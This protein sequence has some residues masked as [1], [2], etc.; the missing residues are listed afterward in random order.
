MASIDS[1]SAF[2]FIAL[3]K[4]S[5]PHRQITGAAILPLTY[6]YQKALQGDVVIN[7]K[8]F[9]DAFRD[10]DDVAVKVFGHNGRSVKALGNV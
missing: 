4:S 9:L 6:L 3:A 8:F 10:E 5:I 7:V 2:H 1:Q